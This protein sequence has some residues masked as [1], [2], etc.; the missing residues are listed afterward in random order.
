MDLNPV[1]NKNLVPDDLDINW[2]AIDADTAMQKLE[3]P[4]QTGLT[5][6]EVKRRQAKY[7]P[8]LL[9][10]KP[11]PTFF[12]L[13]ISQLKNF[14]VIL[15]I[16]AALISAVLGDF[17]E[18]VA[19]MI[20]VVLN[21]VLGVVQESRAEQAL[22]ALKKLAAPD[23]MVI[24]DGRH[25][26]V[27]APQL[28]PGDIVLLEA[29]NFIPADVRLLETVNLKIEEA[30]LTG[31]FVP[32]QK[33]SAMVLEGEVSLGDQKNSAFMGTTV[34]YGRGRGIV[35]SIGM[36]TQLGLIAGM[37]QSVEE[38]QTPLQLR[39]DKLGST[40]G[41][42]ALIVCGLV[43]V[44]GVFQAGFANISLEL[45]TGL[46]MVSVSLAIAA[47]PEGLPAVVTISLA[48]GMQ[49]M[50]QRHAL[51]RR[52]ASVET[53][54]S[55][56]VICSDKTGTLTQNKMTVTRLWADG[57][58]FEITGSGYTSDGDFLVDGQ[59]VSLKDYPAAADTLWVGTL[60][61]DALLE[62]GGR[63]RKKPVPHDRGPHRRLHPDR[64]FQGR[65][66]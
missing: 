44:V 33:N 59:A 1:V 15:L 28:V 5:S 50:V 41:I 2:Y 60:N 42:A 51:I 66:F 26:T 11:R 55:A 31:E 24:R 39:L 64:G 12:Q 4:F 29:G 46:F 61:N 65:N 40:L 62:A 54:G 3:L 38:E 20:I 16:I 30:A 36:L 9:A 56:T 35:T 13:L 32:V 22:A 19:I 7:G 25:Q 57:T 45:V 18:A 48:L 49:E 10:E 27:P 6:E 37:L 23:A 14:I 58:A 52:L 34:T 17:T 53:L 21:A 8:N 47:V 63:Q 43:F